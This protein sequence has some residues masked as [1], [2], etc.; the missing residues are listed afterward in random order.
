MPGKLS[1]DRVR[2]NEDVPA[3]Y[4]LE[5]Q[6]LTQQRGRRRARSAPGVP[7]AARRRSVRPERAV[8]GATDARAA[9]QETDH[10]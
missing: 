8:E 2:H 1:I 6:Q 4:V 5:K 9:A 10:A 3:V 7:P